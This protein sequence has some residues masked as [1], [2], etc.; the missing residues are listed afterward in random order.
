MVRQVVV[1]PAG[2]HG[3]RSDQ[4]ERRERLG[5]VERSDLGDHPADADAR[6]M[7]RPIVEFTGER[8]GVVR[9]VAQG[10]GRSL[11]VDRGR[12]TGVAQ[13]VPHDVAPTARQRLAER[14]GP[15]EHG[16]AAHEQYQRRCGLAEVFDPELDT[17]RLDRRHHS[18]SS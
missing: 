15:G 18:S 8:C 4:G 14:G 7:R 5:V 11:G 2:S 10:V 17:V 12:C 16:R 1:D 6:Q 9:E 3:S 13:V